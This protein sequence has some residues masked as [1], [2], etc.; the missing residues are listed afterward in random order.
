MEPFLNQV[1]MTPHLMDRSGKAE[2]MTRSMRFPLSVAM[3]LFCCSCASQPTGRVQPYADFGCDSSSSQ[4]WASVKTYADLKAAVCRYQATYQ[5]AQLT[6]KP[7]ERSLMSSV[8]SRTLFYQLP[9]SER[10]V[11]IM[12]SFAQV[13]LDGEYA[14]DMDYMLT[15]SSLPKTIKGWDPLTAADRSYTR[16]IFRTIDGY[17]EEQIRAFCWGSD[18]DYERFQKN[19]KI[20]RERC[21]PKLPEQ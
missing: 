14:E 19:L 8:L 11:C 5:R 9:L 13:E 12:D 3:I 2:R 18:K 4:E 16:A 21:I 6:R 1:S 15:Y 20:W 7:E 17:S 10:V